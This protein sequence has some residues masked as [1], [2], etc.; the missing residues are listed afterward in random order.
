MYTLFARKDDASINFAEQNS[1][2]LLKTLHKRL[3][4]VKQAQ[5]EKITNNYEMNKRKY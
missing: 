3:G 2:R 4:Y 5:L 1:T